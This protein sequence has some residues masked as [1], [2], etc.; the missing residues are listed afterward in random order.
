MKDDSSNAISYTLTT[1][2]DGSQTTE[3]EFK[4]ADINSSTAG[5]SQNLG[6]S[7]TWE[8]TQP[9]GTYTDTIT[10]T[11]AVVEAATTT[12]LS[13]IQA[14]YTAQDGETLTGTLGSNVQISIAD[15]AIVTLSGVT[16]VTATAGNYTQGSPNQPIGHGSNGNVGTVSIT[17]ADSKITR[18]SGRE[19][20]V[21]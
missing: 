13:T 9:A 14:A 19:I 15:G 17:A 2:E 12:D 7:I 16:S 4:S 8:S 1:T 5:S 10:Y 11:A 6:I 20:P 21:D 3:Y 18:V